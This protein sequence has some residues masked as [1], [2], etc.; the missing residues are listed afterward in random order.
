[1]AQRQCD[2]KTE[3]GP[4]RTLIAVRNWF[5]RLNGISKR[6]FGA[7]SLFQWNNPRLMSP[8]HITEKGAA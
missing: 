8:G 4:K 3:H 7:E 6:T 5:G 1:M 2:P